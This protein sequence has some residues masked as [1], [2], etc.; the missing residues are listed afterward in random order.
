MRMMWYPTAGFSS[1][2]D[3]LIKKRFWVIASVIGLAK[4]GTSNFERVYRFNKQRLAI[5]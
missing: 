2:L 3:L 4:R 1:C 5:V